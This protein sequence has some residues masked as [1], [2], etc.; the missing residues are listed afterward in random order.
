MWVS[1]MGTSS[2]PP[3]SRGAVV[4]PHL[5]CDSAQAIRIANNCS[6]ALSSCAH[7]G[8]RRAL[9]LVGRDLVRAFSW[10]AFRARFVDRLG[11]PTSWCGGAMCIQRKS[12]WHAGWVGCRRK[13]SDV[14]CVAQRRPQHAGVLS[15]TLHAHARSSASS[16][17]STISHVVGMA[18]ARVTPHVDWHHGM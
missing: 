15:C 17:P 18:C 3:D 1:S 5:Q 11:Q 16:N 13:P 12:A 14:T 10:P 6:F 2:T 4:A 7:S 9:V 8:D